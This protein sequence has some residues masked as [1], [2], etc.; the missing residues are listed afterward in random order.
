MAG[1]PEEEFRALY[2]KTYGFVLHR[3]R[4]ILQ[5]DAE[6][7]DVTHD[8]YLEAW[9][10]WSK[11]RAHPTRVGWLLSCA[12]NRAID[13]LRHRAIVKRHEE[14]EGVESAAPPDMRSNVEIAML[15][16]TVL[17]EEN[18][19]MRR[20]VAHAVLDGTTQEETALLLD[21]SRKTVQRYLDRFRQ[22]CAALFAEEEGVR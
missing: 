19:T 17:R 16:R 21:I 18:E 4:A 8:V 22:K 14:A 11:V 15:L 2:H 5:D 3:A 1:D 13:R 10:A 20:V 12:T 6:A 9:R 7:K